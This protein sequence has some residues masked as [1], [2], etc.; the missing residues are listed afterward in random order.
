MAAP[1]REQ[2]FNFPQHPSSRSTSWYF[3]W[4]SE[5]RPDVIGRTAGETVVF[6]FI[7]AADRQ[8]VHGRI[9]SFPGTA[10]ALCFKVS[11]D[12]MGIPDM[13]FDPEPAR[14]VA[15]RRIER[16]FLGRSI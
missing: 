16:L 12:A 2:H 9:P 4:V 3:L 8:I 7:L 15:R 1:G 13:L 5:R 10:R 14:R 6:E 11:T